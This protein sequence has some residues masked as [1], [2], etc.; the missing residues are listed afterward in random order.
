[1]NFG[2][3]AVKLLN[4]KTE[5]EIEDAISL[6]TD[7]L[8]RSWHGRSAAISTPISGT[9]MAMKRNLNVW[10]RRT[11]GWLTTTGVS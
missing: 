1:M 2:Q 8:V 6:F 4:A 11:K 10:N 3:K 5:Q 7:M 9:L